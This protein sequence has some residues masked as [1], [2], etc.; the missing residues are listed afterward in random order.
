MEFLYAAHVPAGEGPYPTVLALHGWGANAHDLLGLAPYLHGGDALVLCPQ[1]PVTVPVGQGMVGY[2]WFPLS[3]GG[4]LDATQLTMAGLRLKTFLDQAM[5]TYAIDTKHLLVMGFSQGGVMAYDLV[6]KD[7]GHYTGLVA[8]SSWLP[9]ELTPAESLADEHSSLPV[10]VVH[11]SGDPM[12]PIE[13]AQESRDRL[14]K[15]GLSPTYREYDMEH[16]IRPD[17]LRDIVQWAEDKVF[18]PILVA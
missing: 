2:G 14:I 9:P 6:L 13:R 3:G 11:G 17:T 10:M 12:I 8:M 4:E 1:G 16:E 7:P 5:E 15:L 18:S